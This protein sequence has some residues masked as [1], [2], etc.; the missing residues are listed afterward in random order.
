M[1]MIF[2]H[3]GRIAPDPVYGFPRSLTCDDAGR[4]LGAT[5]PLSSHGV[6]TVQVGAL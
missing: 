3:R 1:I 2:K 4:P 5:R 6:V